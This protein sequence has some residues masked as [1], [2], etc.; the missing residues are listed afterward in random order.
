MLH[1]GNS[2]AK[3]RYIEPTLVEVSSAAAAEG[4]ATIMQE[5]IFGPLLPIVTVDSMDEAI[6]MWHLK[7]AAWPKYCLNLRFSGDSLCECSTKAIG[8]LRVRD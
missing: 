6:G 1:G 8:C 4:G 5:E 7:R 2:D 3:E